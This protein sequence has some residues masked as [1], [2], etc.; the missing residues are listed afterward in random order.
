MRLALGLLVCL[1]LGVLVGCSSAPEPDGIYT[2]SQRD[3]GNIAASDSVGA[4][5]CQQNGVQTAFVPDDY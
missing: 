2:F 3:A 4:S 1:T 5:L